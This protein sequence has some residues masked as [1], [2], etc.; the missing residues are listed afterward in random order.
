[1]FNTPNRVMK[2]VVGNVVGGGWQRWL[3]GTRVVWVGGAMV[4]SVEVVW[5]YP[6][7]KYFLHLCWW[8]GAHKP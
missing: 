3:G 2:G 1:M 5:R 7:M 8:V 4:V 6:P